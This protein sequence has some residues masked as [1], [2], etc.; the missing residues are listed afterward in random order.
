MQSVQMGASTMLISF[1]LFGFLR[2][3]RG[4][5]GVVDRILE[6]GSSS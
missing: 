6:L 5:G 3:W 4:G 1:F 2:N